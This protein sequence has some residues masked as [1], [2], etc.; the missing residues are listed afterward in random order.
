MG[1]TVCG[2]RLLELRVPF[3]TASRWV[4]TL[5]VDKLYFA[6]NCRINMDML[7]FF[8]SARIYQLTPPDL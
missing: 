3:A 8:V 2:S 6:E 7:L 5:P 4:A 1:V